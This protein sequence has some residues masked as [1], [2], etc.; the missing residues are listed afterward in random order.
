MFIR[1]FEKNT[2]PEKDFFLSS[3]TGLRLSGRP[4]YPGLAS[5]ATIFCPLRDILNTIICSNPTIRFIFIDICD[6]NHYI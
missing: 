6:M 4:F 2:R 5:W 1:I 3:L